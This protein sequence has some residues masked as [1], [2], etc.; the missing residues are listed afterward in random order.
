MH[1]GSNHGLVNFAP[2]N[3]DGS[4]P[5][6]LAHYKRPTEQER[7]MLAPIRA[8]LEVEGVGTLELSPFK[9]CGFSRMMGPDGVPYP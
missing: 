5:Q 4:T 8:A 1:A 2:K 6:D 9:R 7:P 3:S